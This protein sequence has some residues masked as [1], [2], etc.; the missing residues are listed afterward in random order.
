[1]VGIRVTAVQ[2]I[3]ILSLTI[4]ILVPVDILSLT[5]ADIIIQMIS[6][7]AR[8]SVVAWLLADNEIVIEARANIKGITRAITICILPDSCTLAI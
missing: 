3:G 1:M 8:V 2:I 4:T 7:C 6:D 5:S